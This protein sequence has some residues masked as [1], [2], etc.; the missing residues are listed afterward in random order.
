MKGFPATILTLKF[1]AFV[2]TRSCPAGYPGLAERKA[3]AST[4]CSRFTEAIT[5]T[6]DCAVL[7]YRMTVPSRRPRARVAP[8]VVAASAV[9]SSGATQDPI[10]SRDASVI[11]AVS[12]G[13]DFAQSVGCLVRGSSRR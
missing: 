8:S 1:G 11:G 5:A 4:G 9:I 12:S 13:S 7:L 3:N 6:G 10:F 2:L